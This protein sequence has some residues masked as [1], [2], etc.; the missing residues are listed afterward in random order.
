MPA[1][2][3]HALLLTAGLGTRLQP[4]T[5]VRAK[6]AIPLA[7]EPLVSRITRWLVSH[8]ITELVLNLHYRP[9]SITRVVGDGR[10]L[11]ARVRY[12]WEQPAVLG[13]AGGPRVAAPIVGADPF[14]IVNGDTLTDV[15][16]AAVIGQHQATGALVTM[17][18]VPN[19][20]PNHYGGVRLDADGRVT[21]FARRGPDAVG[22]FHFI[23]V[24]VAAA[25]AFAAVTPGTAAN[26]VGDV[27]DRLIAERP[28]C[29]RGFVSEAG[30]WDIGSVADYWQTTVRF[31]DRSDDDGRGTLG[32][33]GGVRIEASAIVRDSVLWDRVRVGAG[34]R[35]DGCIVTDDVVVPDGAAYRN[36]ILWNDPEQ[37]LTV[38]P[39]P[40]A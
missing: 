14:L 6:P 34:A 7:G 21:G 15:D 18:L 10:H 33:G 23:G 40:L 2:I 32:R 22:T 13:S 26:S 36:S 3:S 38:A 19:T 9:E 4:L 8:G 31:A 25:A 29:I 16:L 37:G 1:P 28:G 39:R 5:F 17:A 27:Y 35:L 12:S 24:Q 20:M 11:G 30:F